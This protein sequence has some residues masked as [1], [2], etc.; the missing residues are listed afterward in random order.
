MPSKGGLQ[1]YTAM[2]EGLRQGRERAEK[3]GEMIK[4]MGEKY[5]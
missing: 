2:M 1:T 4:E 3:A 5:E